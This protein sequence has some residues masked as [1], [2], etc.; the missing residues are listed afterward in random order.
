M[1]TRRH[2]LAAAAVAAAIL[3]SF[4]IAVPAQ[5]STTVTTFTDLQAAFANAPLNAQTDIVLGADI[6]EPGSATSYLSVPNL[7][8]SGAASVTLDLAGHLLSIG[9]NSEDFAGIEVRKGATLTI[10]DSVG[11][12]TLAITT[13]QYGAGIGVSYDQSDPDGS[14]WVPSTFGYQSGGTVVV[15]AGTLNITG[16]YLS[17][18]IG[19]A[20]Y[21]GGMDITIHGGTLNLVG[22]DGAAALGNGSY[23]YL[24]TEATHITI[25]GGVIH[26]T[27]GAGGGPGI[28][29]ASGTDNTVSQGSVVVNGCPTIDA[30]G[31]PSD[32]YVPGGSAAIGA[33]AEVPGY[34]VTPDPL[35][36]YGTVDGETP[37]NGGSGGP[38]NGGLGSPI[39]IQ[40]DAHFLISM[41]S[42]EGAANLGGQFSLRCTA[43]PDAAGLAKTGPE[44]SSIELVFGAGLLVLGLLIIAI[45]RRRSA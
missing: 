15:N 37:Q 23:Q 14:G 1:T 6:I 34:L 10:D 22:G 26:A 12:G 39:T 25:T 41:T 40:P 19:G 5:A 18:A 9:A 11:G 33:G 3:S 17:S 38:M 21:Y 27:G 16:G 28:G 29:R 4:A 20:Y 2:I 24:T 45:R 30:F 13:N 32:P 7:G 31:G 8:S 36:I 43:V 35:T 42:T 44:T